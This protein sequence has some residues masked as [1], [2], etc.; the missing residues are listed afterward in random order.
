MCLD[1]FLYCWVV[2][3]V[4]YVTLRLVGEQIGNTISKLHEQYVVRGSKVFRLPK[5]ADRL[6]ECECLAY[7][8]S[9][10]LGHAEFIGLWLGI[11]AIGRWTSNGP[12]SIVDC[13]PELGDTK[14]VRIRAEISGRKKAELNIYL[15]GC[16]FNVLLGGLVGFFLKMLLP[17]PN[18]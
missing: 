18:R 12:E 6:G 9:Y 13:M 11:K 7:A 16:L 4:A 10:Y 17:L 8:T 5:L 15:L 2:L 14:D 1:G 3:S